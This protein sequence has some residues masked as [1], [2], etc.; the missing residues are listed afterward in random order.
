MAGLRDEVI[1]DPLGRGYSG[2]T[3]SEV[4][5]DGHIEYRTRNRISMTASEIANQI[6]VAEFNVLSAVDKAEIWNV[7]HLG[8]I[9]PHGVEATIFQNIFGASDTI[10]NLQ[11]ARVESI[12]RW[13]ELGLGNVKV[14]H[15]AIA[16]S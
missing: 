12:S 16:R 13:T 11:A 15:I 9:N 6:S 4:W 10:T 3:A 7:L 8:E 1:N 2:M 5:A 14:G